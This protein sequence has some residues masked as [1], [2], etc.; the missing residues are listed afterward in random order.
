[1][2]QHLVRVHFHWQPQ[3]RRE[4]ARYEEAA[5][6]LVAVRPTPLLLTRENEPLPQHELRVS[7]FAVLNSTLLSEEHLAALD[8]AHFALG[9]Q[10]AHAHSR[11]V[12]AL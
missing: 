11:S 8:G 5:V 7:L 1:M 12:K 10:V 4:S 3:S 6:E 9:S 2:G